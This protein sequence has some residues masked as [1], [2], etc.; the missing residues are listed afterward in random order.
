MSTR[1][2]ITYIAI[3]QLETLQYDRFIEMCKCVKV[4]CGYSGIISENIAIDILQ[5]LS[6][7]KQLK[8]LKFLRKNADW[9]DLCAKIS[10]D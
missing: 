9:N 7:F 6:K 5:N 1:F 10:L 8:I 2:I 4:Y 3:R